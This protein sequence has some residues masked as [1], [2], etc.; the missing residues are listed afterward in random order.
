[1]RRTRPLTDDELRQ[2]YAQQYGDRSE[3]MTFEEF[4]RK[5]AIRWQA[6]KWLKAEL[7]KRRWIYQDVADAMTALGAEVTVAAIDTWFSDRYPKDPTDGNIN[8]FAKVMG[9]TEQDVRKTLGLSA[10]LALSSAAR[11]FA[12]KAEELRRMSETDFQALEVLSDHLVEKN[13]R[14]EQERKKRQRDADASTDCEPAAG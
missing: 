1:M 4:Q 12:L 8:A 14:E 2:A 3:G 13:R 5:S 9:I 11:R 10:E 7:K 6:K